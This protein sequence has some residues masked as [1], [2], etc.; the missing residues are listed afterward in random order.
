MSGDL[1]TGG[2]L[3]TVTLAAHEIEQQTGKKPA[4]KPL[5]AECANCGSRLTGSFCHACGQSANVHRSLLR[6]F[7]EALHGVLHFE[8]KSWRTLPLLIARPGLLTKRYIDGQRVRYV[9]PLALFLFS[10]FLM[11]F[12]VS[13]LESPAD[14]VAA[15]SME[16]QATARAT[17]QTEVDTLRQRV[18]ELAAESQSIPEP[19]NRGQTTEQLADA[20]T[21]LRIAEAALA[22]FDRAAARGRSD[23]ASTV[24][25]TPRM[26]VK[27]NFEF[28]D[29]KIDYVMR[30]A[31]ENPE[32]MAYKIRNT[33]YKFSFM[34]IPISLPFL[35]L[36]FF[37]RRNVTLYDHTIFSMYSL[38]F[39]SLLV[40]LVTL[41]SKIPSIGNLG[42]Y[43]MAAPPLHMFL[44]LKETYGLG[45]FSTL[46]RTIALIFSGSAAF[47]LFLVMVI[48]I[49]VD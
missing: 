24:A 28:G 10:A 25:N 34:L 15:M 41:I 7:E 21:E 16:E 30:Q 2:A 14:R 1:E 46:W 29:T 39:M 11:F 12:A 5:R 9:S 31:Q 27:F 8:S 44:Q 42:E 18:T 48:A 19:P 35:W 20:T 45:F 13:Q 4:E 23:D 47:I 49:S 37:W 3:A 32:L 33:A 22:A 43:L 36:M 38:S 40:T 6:M 26:N 17:L